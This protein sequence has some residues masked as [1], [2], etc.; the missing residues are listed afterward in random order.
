MGDPN[1]SLSVLGTSIRQDSEGRYCLNDCHKAAG[2]EPGKAPSEWVKNAQTKALIGEIRVSGN[3]PTPINVVT[4]G[5]N[6]RRGTFACK[7]LVYAYAM[8]ISAKFHLMVI[9]AFDD[10]MQGNISAA[11]SNHAFDPT[12][13]IALVLSQFPNLSQISRQCMIANVAEVAFGRPVLPL[14]TIDERTYTATEVGKMLGGISANLVGRTAKAHGLKT[15]HYG[16]FV[17]DKSRHSTKQVEAFR[18]NQAGINALRD[19]FLARD[20]AA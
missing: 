14:P 12:N 6:D 7:E 20:K 19:I 15:S 11:N 17:M 1:I 16:I 13:F 10:L 5:P 3:I 18:Y 9:R 8:W 4:A 2:G